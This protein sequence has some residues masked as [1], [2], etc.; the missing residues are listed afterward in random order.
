MDHVIIYFSDII[1]LIVVI[2]L[3]FLPKIAAW[4]SIR[5][6]KKI[7]I[8]FFIFKNLK[9]PIPVLSC[10]GRSKEAKNKVQQSLLISGLG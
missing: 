1:L 6:I 7:G 8:I 10:V 5:V 4:I 2:L 9:K 3:Y